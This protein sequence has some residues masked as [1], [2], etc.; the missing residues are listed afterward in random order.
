MEIAKEI[1]KIRQI[2]LEKIKEADKIYTD[3]ELE[4]WFYGLESINDRQGIAKFYNSFRTVHLAITLLLME[5]GE[6]SQETITEIWSWVQKSKARSLSR[7][8]G[9]RSNIPPGLMNEILA[10]T[11][12]LPIY[13]EM[14]DL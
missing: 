6:I 3:S 10:S 13:E 14:L 5:V 7:T 8:I 11:D 4:S 9:R 1:S 12:A 2:G